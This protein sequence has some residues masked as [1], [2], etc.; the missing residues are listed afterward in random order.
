MVLAPEH[1]LVKELVAGT[2]YEADVDAFVAKM[3]TMTEI[4]RT[5]TDVEKEGMFIGKYVI[6]PVNGNKVPVWIANYVLADYG[7]GAIMAVPAHDERD[8]EFAQ[9]YDLE[10]IPVID[11]DNKMINS[12]EFNGM[13]ASE[14]FDKIIEKIEEM[15]RGKKTV[16]YRLRDWLLSRQRYWGCPIPVVYCDTCGV[17]P[18]KKENLP[19]LLPTDV[20]FTGKGESPLTTSKE[21]MTT[22]CPCCGKEAR[23]EVDTMDTFRRFF[24]VFLKIH[25]S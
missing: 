4:E 18:E 8:R 13:D 5:S 19:V 25:R 12:G 22:A 1:E 20:E 2:E 9:K 6:N 15:N 10:V 3:H 21:F 7:T 17:V 24:L 14:A 11:E 16:N 23:R